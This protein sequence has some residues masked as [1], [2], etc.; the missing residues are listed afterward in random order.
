[1]ENIANLQSWKSTFGLLPIHLNQATFDEKYIMLNGGI[2]D[3]CLQLDDLNQPENRVYSNAWSSNTKNYIVIDNQVLQIF[4]WATLKVEEI[5]ISEATNN[6][7][8]LYDYIYKKSFK[9]NDDI[10]PFILDIFKQFRNLTKESS[11]PSN[12]LN[13]LFLLILSLEENVDTLNFDNWGISETIVPGNFENYSSRLRDGI[14]DLR[15]NLDLILR[16]TAGK[17]FQEAQKEVLF[18]DSQIDIFG[19]TS[20]N[21]IFRENSYSSIHYTPSFLSRTIVEHSISLLDLNGDTLVIF[22]PACGSGEFLVEALKQLRERQFTGTV[23]VIGFDNSEMAASTTRFL[24]NYEKRS[25]WNDRLTFEV[26]R[27]EDSLSANWDIGADILLMNP[28]FLSWNLLNSGSERDAVREILG[29]LFHG[30]PNQSSAFL[31][32][33]IDCIEATSGILGCVLPSSI[34]TSQSYIKL[35][36]SIEDR[37][38]F[39]LIGKLGNFVFEDALTDVSMIVGVKKN[40]DNDSVPKILWTHNRTGVVKTSLRE[41]RKLEYS[42]RFSVSKDDFSIYQPIKFPMFSDSWKTLSMN[43][44]K[45]VKSIQRFK[46]SGK[47]V[48]VGEIF[49]V[50]QGLNSG[51]NSLFKISRKKYDNLEKKEKKLFQPVIDNSAILKGVLSKVNYVWFP[52]NKNGSLFATEDDFQANAPN[53]YSILLPHKNQ[54]KARRGKNDQWWLL[55]EHRKWLL[56]STSRLVS[57]RFGNSKSFAID[58]NGEFVVENGNAWIP[59][60]VFDDKYLYFYLAVFSN[61]LFDKLLSIYS[62]Q[63]SGGSW[64]DLGNKYSKRIPIPNIYL[65]SVK[66]LSVTNKLIEIGKEIADGNY[67]ASSA[68]TYLLKDYFYPNLK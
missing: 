53:F 54:L 49:N 10:V 67:F 24:L 43:E 42:E 20:K 19:E 27:V 30:K 46:G 59:K 25:V 61:P 21:I 51:N 45:F 8:K 56:K 7:G 15:P 33:A 14:G 12:A 60:R 41:L 44:N 58:V 23:K 57:T 36:S 35:R 2:G 17:L 13:L 62:K 39:K 34:L 4:N 29:D 11:D 47:L 18:F 50:R 26:S 65:D 40:R 31:K 16:H 9:S 48:E 22:D 68:A 1:M 37:F 3:F 6:F 55:S 66:E 5:P 63:L 64:Y 52:Y 28:P 38:D 32:K